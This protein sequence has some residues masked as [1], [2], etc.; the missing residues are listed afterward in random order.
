MP[1]ILQIIIGGLMI[2]AIYA[3]M[4]MAYSLICSSTGLLTFAQGEIFMVSAF[5]ALGFYMTM[6]FPF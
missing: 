2:G 6:G 3:L 4:G 5:V 1:M